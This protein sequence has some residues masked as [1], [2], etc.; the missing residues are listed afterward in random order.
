MGFVSSV[1]KHLIGYNAD[2]RIAFENR[3]TGNSRIEEPVC[4][5]GTVEVGGVIGELSRLGRRK[6]VLEGIPVLARLRKFCNCR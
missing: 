2:L 4:L 1:P 3:G 6:T 5:D